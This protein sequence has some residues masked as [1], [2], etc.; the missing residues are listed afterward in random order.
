M[1]SYIPYYGH[2]KIIEYT[3]DQWVE[4]I[5]VVTRYDINKPRKTKLDL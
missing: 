3:M 5:I 4:Y 1:A 2:I